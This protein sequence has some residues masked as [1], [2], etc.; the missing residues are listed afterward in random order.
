MNIKNSKGYLVMKKSSLIVILM[1]IVAFCFVSCSSLN[2][3]VALSQN[4]AVE[5]KNGIKR[6]D[7]VIHDQ[8]TKK[9]HY[10]TGFGEGKTFETAKMKA[11][12]NADSELA[13]WISTT[14][15]AVRDRYIEESTDNLSETF[16]DKFVYSAKEAGQALVTGIIEED[17]WEDAEG[18]VWVLI[19]LPVENVKAQINAA[20]AATCADTSVFTGDSDKV[21]NE[22]MSVVDKV[23]Q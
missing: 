3:K 14:I 9:V 1:L 22:I 11:K 19:S 13:L 15:D 17:F 7:W 4:K 6:P 23:I 21:V 5:G 2:H 16:V 10:S 20:I 18:G 12:L 8:S